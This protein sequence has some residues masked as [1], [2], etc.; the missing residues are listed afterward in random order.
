MRHERS[1]LPETDGNKKFILSDLKILGKRSE[2]YLELNQTPT[3]EL[4][5]ENSDELLAANYYHEKSSV[6][7]VWVVSINASEGSLG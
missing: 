1:V 4:L 6:I 3:M 7:D 2:S 5:C